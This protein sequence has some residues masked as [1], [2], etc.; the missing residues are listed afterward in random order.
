M[1][2]RCQRGC[3]AAGSKAYPTAEEAQR[4]AAAFDRED[5]EDLGRRAPLFGLFPLRLWRR[6]R[7]GR[8]VAAAGPSS[9]RSGR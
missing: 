1:T 5:R 4:F 6:L 9:K 8:A 2:W 7:A 3:G